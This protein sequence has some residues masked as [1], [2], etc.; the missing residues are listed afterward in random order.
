MVCAIPQFWLVLQSHQEVV[1]TQNAVLGMFGCKGVFI[2]HFLIFRNP[3]THW[4]LCYILSLN[5]CSMYGPMSMRSWARRAV[6]QDRPL[7]G[8]HDCQ[9]HIPLLAEQCHGLKVTEPWVWIT[10][11]FRSEGTSAGFL[12]LNIG[13][14]LSALSRPWR[15]G[16]SVGLEVRNQ[17]STNSSYIKDAASFLLRRRLTWD[18]FKPLKT[19]PK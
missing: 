19:K 8:T 13:S 16:Q 18:M 15:G 2:I 9:W 6:G 17:F 4:V 14:K 7:S 12:F 11:S 3:D 5:V 10:G 1:M